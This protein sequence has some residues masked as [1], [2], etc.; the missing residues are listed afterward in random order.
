MAKRRKRVHYT[1]RMDEEVFSSIEKEADEKGITTSSL[2][3]RIVQNYVKRDRFLEQ[4][5]FIPVGKDVMRAWLNRIEDDFLKK[6]AKK[7]GS[8]IAREYVSYFFH[9]VNK[10][11]LIQFLDVWLCTLGDMQKREHHGTYSFV[12]NHGVNVQYSYYL[13]EFL[14]ALIGPIISKRV[15][16]VGIT[17]NL[18]SFSFEVE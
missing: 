10:N 5:G 16:F 12:I 4:L 1:F 15:N 17:P 9:D 14:S 11:T 3:S 8:T 6:D 13:Q 2:L 7:L 18:L